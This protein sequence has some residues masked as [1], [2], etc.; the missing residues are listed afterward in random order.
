MEHAGQMPCETR[1][2]PAASTWQHQAHT[3][4][5]PSIPLRPPLDHGLRASPPSQSGKALTAGAREAGRVATRYGGSYT[6]RMAEFTRDGVTL[7]YETR[8]DP[9]TP[10]V[11][12]LHGFTMDGRM[13]LGSIEALAATFHVIVPDLRGHGRSSAPD[14]PDAYSMEIYGEDLRALLDH[15][16]IGISALAGCSFGGMVALQFATA[17]PERIACLVLSDTSP[18]YAS[19]RYDDAFRERQRRMLEAE[20][21]VRALGTAE[22]GRR[23]ARSVKDPFL[24]E[25]LRRRYAAML[26]EGYLGAS[27]ARRE[28]PDLIPLLRERLTF[29]VLLCVGDEDPA[30]AGTRVL[31]E[32]LPAARVI[33]FRGT[34]HGVPVIRAEAFTDAVMRFFREIEEGRF[35]GGERSV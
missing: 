12:L 5:M 25:A 18:A 10:P 9:E 22:L 29:P 19:D 35:V 1:S 21:M 20:E 8:G 15:L 32:E 27:R 7:F 16:E 11:V 13:W 24:A 17:W 14:D 6:P 30:G 2:P 23:A 26:P 3:S 34:G 31:A 28:R 4:V 33:T